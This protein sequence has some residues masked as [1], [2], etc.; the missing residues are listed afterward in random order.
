MAN[1]QAV[2]PT[3]LLQARPVDKTVER[4]GVPTKYDERCIQLH[5][6][7]LTGRLGY[8]VD[9]RKPVR[10]FPTSRIHADIYKACP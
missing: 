4:S 9:T 7:H 5:T 1:L 10:G 6:V 8:A 3:S 2:A